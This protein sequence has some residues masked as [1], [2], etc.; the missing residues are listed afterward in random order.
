MKKNITINLFNQLYHIDE[1]AYELLNNYL[2]SLRTYFAKREGGDE[3]AEDIEARVGELLNEMKMNGK[4]VVTIED[5]EAVIK[6]V[7]ELN[8][9]GSEEEEDTT[10][11]DTNTKENMADQSGKYRKYYRDADDKLLGGVISGLTKYFGGKK[12]ENSTSALYDPR[13]WRLAVISMLFIGCPLLQFFFFIPIPIN[14]ALI[15]IPYFLLWIFAPAATTANERLMMKGTPV[16]PETL[17][18]EARK[19]AKDTE[20]KKMGGKAGSI[21]SSLLLFVV[22]IIKTLLMLAAAVTIGIGITGIVGAIF[23][24]EITLGFI[25]GNIHPPFTPQEFSLLMIGFS[26]L[27]IVASIIFF[28]LITKKKKEEN[29]CS[30]H[31]IQRIMNVLWIVM[32][33]ISL[34]SFTAFGKTRHANERK[35]YYERNTRK[36]IFIEESS[37]RMLEA[38]GLSLDKADNVS[39][40]VLSKD[41]DP[42]T[43][44]RNHRF[45]YLHEG[46]KGHPMEFEVSKVFKI[47]KSGTYS[48]DILY[49][50]EGANHLPYTFNGEYGVFNAAWHIASLKSIK[51]NFA[52]DIPMLKATGDSTSWKRIQEEADSLGWRWGQIIYYCRDSSDTVKVT[53]KQNSNTINE[54]GEIIDGLTIIDIKMRKV[55]HVAIPSAKF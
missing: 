54:Y 36:G 24:P 28:Q 45:I 12:G 34:V 2:K 53:L 41:Y 16:N 39:P 26:S 11:T 33:V 47:E 42:R 52:K 17:T 38:Q 31:Q 7:G 8:Q 40:Y 5:V 13:F 48:I 4:D 1:D 25:T 22:N 55:E 20:I 43:G 3:I 15:I 18:E 29:D 19:M 6:R 9:I 21:I 30:N 46:E 49:K 32:A 23:Y 10:D 44:D 51:W 35:E 27:I 14:F 37:W 50:I